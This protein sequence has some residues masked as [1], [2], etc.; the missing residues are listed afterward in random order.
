MAT[1]YAT[2]PFNSF[3][4]T[5]PVGSAGVDLSQLFISPSL[6]YRVNENHAL[7]IAVNLAYQRFRADGIQ[8]FTG[9]SQSPND[10]TNRG[11]DSST[12]W[13][14]RLGYTGQIMP[15]VTVGLT[16]ASKTYMGKFDKYKGL[17]A[18][19]G[20]FGIPSNYGVGVAWKA[21]GNLTV[22]ADLQRILYSDVKSVGATFDINKL[23][24][25]NFYG[26]DGGPGFGW[27]DV[28]VGKLGVSYTTGDWTLRSGY[29][30]V[31]QPVQES[32]TFMNILAPGVVQQHISFGATWAQ[33]KTGEL[34][35]GYTHAFKKTVKG[36]GSIPQGFGGGEADVHLSEDILGVAYGW[37]F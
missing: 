20:G 18:E 10:M 36:S 33:G 14:V 22:A 23:M 1:D 31:T 13:G 34:S 28:T 11:Y 24:A 37:K 9:Y 15:D 5:G 26:S 16:W 12:G 35:V 32:Q 29:S 3:S 27:K 21:T 8:P 4:P 30:Y 19:Q 6:A 17:F 2:S 25:G 7:G